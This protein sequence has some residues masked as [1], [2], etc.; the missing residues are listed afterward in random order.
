MSIREQLLALKIPT[1]TVKVAGIEG[2]V[3][4]RGLTASERDLWEQ[5][6]YSERDIKKGEEHPRQP[7]REVFNRRR[8]WRA[9]VYRCGDCGSGR[10]ACIRN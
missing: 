6:I 2:L 4:L 8:D 9:I 10:N 7:R 5:G 3:S 1:A